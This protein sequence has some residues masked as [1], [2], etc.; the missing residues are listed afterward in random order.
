MDTALRPLARATSSASAIP[1]VFLF[2]RCPLVVPKPPMSVRENTNDQFTKEGRELAV[3]EAGRTNWS[4]TAVK[5]RNGELDDSGTVARTV[6]F[7]AQIRET[8]GL[9]H[10]MKVVVDAKTKACVRVL[11]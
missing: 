9:G 11:I 8:G 1:V 5:H 2:R 7:G 6:H 4:G 10:L 3:I